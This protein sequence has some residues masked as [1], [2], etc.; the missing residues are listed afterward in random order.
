MVENIGIAC[1][2][3]KQNEI[4]NANNRNFDAVGG[5]CVR[6]VAQEA[7]EFSIPIEVTEENFSQTAGGFQ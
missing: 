1:P 5:M 3:C 6:R 4:G 2:R 7:L